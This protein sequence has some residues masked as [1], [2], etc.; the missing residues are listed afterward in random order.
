MQQVSIAGMFGETSAF[1]GGIT[2]VNFG[3]GGGFGFGAEAN[4]TAVASPFV[5]ADTPEMADMNFDVD[6]F[7]IGGG[8]GG[9]SAAKAAAALGKR[10]ALADFVRPSPKGTT[11][12]L[13]GTCVNVGCIP[14]KLMHTAA[15]MG[16]HVHH[17]S[18]Y[19]GWGGEPVEEYNENFEIVHPKV[20]AANWQR[21]R[22]NVTNHIGSLN[23][24]YTS[25]LGKN[26][27]TYHNAYAKFIDAHTLELTDAAGAAQTVTARRIVLATGGRPTLLDIPGADLCVTSDDLFTLPTPPGKTLFVGASYVSLECAGFVNGLGFEAHVMMRSIPLRGFDTD[28]AERVVK[29]MEGRGVKFIRG[30]QPSSVVKDDD[31]RLTVTFSDGSGEA[32]TEIFDTV[33]MA[34]GRR[35][36]VTRINLAVTGVETSA[37]SGKIIVNAGDQTN[38]PH[39]YAIGDIIEG[40]L[41]LTPVAIRAG[42]LLAARLFGGKTEVMSYKN[43]PTTVFTPLEYGCVGLSEEDAA[44]QYGTV[45]VYHTAFTPLEWNLPHFATNECYMKLI[46]NPADDERVV[47][48]H[49]LS[50]NAGEITQGIAVAIRSGAKKRDFDETIGIHPTVAE[51]MTLLR[52]TKSSGEDPNKAGC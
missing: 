8:S 11:W 44:A 6:L 20:P 32:T 2:R 17:A 26:G 29:S 25:E 37:T 4:D 38:V 18:P 41:E 5:D 1:G 42:K 10:V 48:F 13:G 12:G 51:D 3:T 28:M 46:V 7:V 24:G 19:Y 21:L 15:I 35:P 30:A 47:G 14:K 33:C 43:V 45:E 39:I 23:W 36:E 50:P 40:G 49:I 27:I 31:G 16:E 9:I 52:V 34:V 22:D